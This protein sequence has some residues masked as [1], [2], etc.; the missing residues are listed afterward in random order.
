MLRGVGVLC[1]GRRGVGKDE[2]MRREGEGGSEGR[3]TGRLG[4]TV[5]YGSAT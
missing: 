1:R 4:Q 5:S 3:I 2:E